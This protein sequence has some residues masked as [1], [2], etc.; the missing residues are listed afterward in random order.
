MR[1]DVVGRQI[2][3]TDPIREYAEKKCEKLTRFFDQIQQITVT[4]ASTEHK[5]GREFDV[6]FL[7]DVEHHPSFIARAEDGD[8]YAGIDRAQEKAVRQL[9]DFKE[10]LKTG[11]R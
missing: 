4:V 2:E 8:L 1:I 9:T 7:V 5:S 10:K 6:E 3:I 11:N